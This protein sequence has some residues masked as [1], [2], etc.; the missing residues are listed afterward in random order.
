M[1]QTY[2][3]NCV[4]NMTLA[5]YMHAQPKADTQVKRMAKR[6][7]RRA[8]SDDK[9]ARRTLRNVVKTGQPCLLVQIAYDEITGGSD[10]GVS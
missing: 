6:Y 10:V 3:W 8:P 4:V 5:S 7:M 2:L 9:L 1:E